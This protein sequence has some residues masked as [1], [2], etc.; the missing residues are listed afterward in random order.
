MA[1]RSGIG[2]TEETDKEKNKTI[3][4]TVRGS[5]IKTN[6]IG[7]TEVGGVTSAVAGVGS[8]IVK[9]VE[10][11]VSLGAELMDLGA[12]QMLNLPSTK[13]SVVSAAQEVEE[14]FD[15]LNVFEETAN[16]RA[17]GKITQA[18]VQIGLPASAGSKI[19]LKL[20]NK[21][22]SAK[23]AGKY[24][25]VMSKNAQKGIKK[26]KELNKLTGKKRFGALVLRG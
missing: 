4:R 7:D 19:A 9:T 12:G 26:A 13:G 25:N 23:K 15:K 1:L 14:F 3:E 20:A 24:A 18:L 17:A 10:G 16:A 2:I 5:K 22:I 8:G 21:A 6:E 11:V